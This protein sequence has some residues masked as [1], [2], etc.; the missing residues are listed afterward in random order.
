MNVGIGNETTQFHFWKQDFRYSVAQKTPMC[1]YLV[2][3]EFQLMEADGGGESYCAR[4]TERQSFVYAALQQFYIKQSLLKMRSKKDGLLSASSIFFVAQRHPLPQHKNTKNR[5]KL[6]FILILKIPYI[7]PYY[8]SL[9][10][11][12]VYKPRIIV[13]FPARQIKSLSNKVS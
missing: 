11:F 12:I 2:L 5:S 13:F 1:H 8:K 4:V 10:A 3:C 6:Q 7:K 9:S